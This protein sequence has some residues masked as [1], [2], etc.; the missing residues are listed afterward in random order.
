LATNAV[1]TETQTKQ[2]NAAGFTLLEIMIIVSIIGTLAAVAI[3][4]MLRARARAQENT[5]IEHLRIIDAAKQQWALENKASPTSS[6][7]AA[8]VKPYMGH[9]IGELP[10]CPSDPSQTFASSYTLNDCST[11]PSCLIVATHALP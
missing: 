2:S 7:T 8:Q 5:C 1:K 11:A 4:G 6:P 10:V 3:P 9:G